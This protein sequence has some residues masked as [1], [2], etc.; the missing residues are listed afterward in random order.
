MPSPLK[1]DASRQWMFT[2]SLSQPIFY[3][4]RDH[5]NMFTDLGK[6]WSSGPPSNY[7]TWVPMRYFI[8]LDFHEYEINTYVNDHNIIDKPLRE[9]DNG[10]SLFVQMTV[11]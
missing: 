9:E 11:C 4:L 8:I 1:W 5:I 3:L 7:F 6:D 10:L 2:V